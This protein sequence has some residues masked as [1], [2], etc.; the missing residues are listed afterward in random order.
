MAQK[1][2]DERVVS[3]RLAYQAFKIS[4][5]CYR[6][7][8][9]LS[10]ENAEIADWLIRLTTTYRNWRFKLW[11]FYFRNVKGY[12]WKHKRVYP[13]F[14]ELELNLRIKPKKRLVREK[15]EPLDVPEA[16]NQIRSMHFMNDQLLDGHSSR[17]FNLLD[18][19][20]REG[21]AIEADFSLPSERVTR[22]LDQIIEWRG[23]P[24]AIRCDDGVEYIS[25][26]LAQWAEKHEIRLV[27]IQP[28]KPQQNAYV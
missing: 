26:H 3:I 28:E 16:V 18:D 22:S 8:P 17:L 27:F 24:N 14:R 21:L 6:Y 7:Q 10:T 11:N 5:A 20:N 19:F 13:N 1:Q 25:N 15:T 23:K 2:V 9:I 4:Q 12:G